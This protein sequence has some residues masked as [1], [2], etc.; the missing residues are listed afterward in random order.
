MVGA[1]IDVAVRFG[2]PRDSSAVVRK[3]AEV[4]RLLVAAPSYVRATGAPAAPDDLREFA[5]LIGPAGRR[6][7]AW[8]FR[9][10]DETVSVRV[11]SRLS[12]SENDGA[13]AAAVA[14]LGITS[15]GLWGCRAELSDGRLVRLLPDWGLGA[16]GVYA[17]FAAGRAAKPSACAIIGHL[18]QDL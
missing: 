9:R 4:P 13:I 14:G 8:T 16:V 15:T 2:T 12:F 11:E 10:D 6:R 3:L 7:E 17:Q 18:K 5:I 1:G